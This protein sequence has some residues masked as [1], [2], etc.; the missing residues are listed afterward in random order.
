MTNTIKFP[1]KEILAFKEE[2]ASVLFEGDDSELASLRVSDAHDLLFLVESLA[3]K[4]EVALEVFSDLLQNKPTLLEYLPETLFNYLDWWLEK[5]I[6]SIV[7]AARAQAAP[8]LP[9]KKVFLENE[10]N[11]G[12]K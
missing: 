12:A 1:K 3:A 2:L 11:G 5:V 7:Q 8:A 6:I 10:E 4:D 9:P